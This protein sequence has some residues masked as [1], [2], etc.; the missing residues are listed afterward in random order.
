MMLLTIRWNR[1]DVENNYIEF[2]SQEMMC[3]AC[4]WQYDGC[5]NFCCAK[6]E[7]KPPKCTGMEVVDDNEMRSAPANFSLTRRQQ[8]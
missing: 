8:L 5:G 2:K 3:L 4:S 1:I 6:V 7:F